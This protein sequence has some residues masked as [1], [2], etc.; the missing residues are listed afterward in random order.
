MESSPAPK[1][2]SYCSNEPRRGPRPDVDLEV[3]AAARTLGGD[4][5]RAALVDLPV[6]LLQVGEVRGEEPLDDARVH[7]AFLEVAE[8]GD[9]PREQ[10][11]DEVGAVV[12]HPEVLKGD[13]L[14]LGGG[15]PHH[16]LAV[17]VAVLVDESLGQREFELGLEGHR[18]GA[19]SGSETRPGD[20]ETTRA[21]VQPTA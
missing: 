21:D 5:R 14:V 12:L 15:Q 2:L 13:D 17:Q 16:S 11:D 9:H 18:G 20:V 1:I 3:L 8:L 10:D 4:V 7:L 6:E 19:P